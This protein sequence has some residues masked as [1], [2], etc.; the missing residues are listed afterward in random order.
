MNAGYGE[1]RA[2]VLAGAQTA[3]GPED[4]ATA[5]YDHGLGEFEVGDFVVDEG[6]RQQFFRQLRERRREDWVTYIYCNNE[7]EVERLQ[8]LL[9]EEEYK[10]IVFAIGS[11]ARGF[12]FPAGKLAVLS[13]AELFGRYR[14]TRARRL[15]MRRMREQAN[16][17][18]IDFSELN[19][20]DYVVHLEHGIG[21]FLGLRTFATDGKEEEVLMLEFEG[22]SRLYVPLEQSFLV[23]RYVGVGKRSP[24]LSSL[25][26][27]RWAKAKKNA[28]QAIF[29]YAAQL[30]SVHAQRET[31]TG[32]AFPPDSKWVGEFE[33]SFFSTRRP[34]IN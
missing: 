7:G 18:H 11:I 28:E 34:R 13:D 1:A 22:D 5:F 32:F 33:H 14:N 15:A 27:A 26:D 25:G 9:A 2:H 8:E 3:D 23:S 30:L 10:N 20:G 24:A 16:R 29:S 6:K 4:F 31:S 12:T 21:K 17:T 19:E